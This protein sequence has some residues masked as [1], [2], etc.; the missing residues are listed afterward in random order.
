MER[1]FQITGAEETKGLK[2]GWAMMENACETIVGRA[3]RWVK[4][5]S[6]SLR[7]GRIKRAWRPDGKLVKIEIVYLN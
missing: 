7:W 5:E 6:K 1:L 2:R 4:K 3:G